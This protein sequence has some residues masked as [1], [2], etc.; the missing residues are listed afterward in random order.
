MEGLLPTRTLAAG[1]AFLAMAGLGGPARGASLDCSE[2]ARCETLRGFFAHYGSPLGAS[3]EVFLEKADEYGLDW[4]LLPAIAMVES[5]G[6]RYARH[7]NIFGWNSGRT[8]FRTVAAG[9]DYVASRLAH[10][11][12]YRGRTSREILRAYNP[13]RRLYPLRVIRY[14]ELLTSS[15]VP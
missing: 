14:M 6:G 15:P 1:V 12:M 4:R 11:P 2:D 8:R 13:S 9:I 10:S 5:G 3:A 7:N